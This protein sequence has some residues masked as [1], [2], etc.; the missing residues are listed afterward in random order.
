MSRKTIAID[1][2]DVLARSAEGF[3]AFS[4]EQWGSNMTPDHH[5]EDWV[6][7]WGVSLDEALERSKVVHASGVMGRY[8]HYEAAL[9][10]LVA[11]HGKYDLVV[12]TSRRLVLKPETDQWIEDRFPGLFSAVHYAGI[13]DGTNKDDAYKRLKYTK[14]EICREIGAD[15]LIDDQLKHCL[16]AAEAGLEVLLFGNYKWNQSAKL[17]K[18]VTRVA[19][20]PAVQ[21]YFDAKG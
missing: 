3:A 20:W 21:E 14:A 17:P 9:P 7:A 18:K 11:L 6:V 4:N 19:G 13:W 1:I 10:V 15:Y 2:D 16:A 5:T 8:E 12:L